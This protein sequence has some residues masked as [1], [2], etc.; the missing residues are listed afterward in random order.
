MLCPQRSYKYFV[1]L[2]D[3]RKGQP[4]PKNIMFSKAKGADPFFRPYHL[5]GPAVP[6]FA[7]SPSVSWRLVKQQA[8]QSC[9][10]VTPFPVQA[11]SRSGLIQRAR[12]YTAKTS[13]RK[14]FL[15]LLKPEFATQGWDGSYNPNSLIN[16]IFSARFE[17]ACLRS[18]KRACAQQAGA[19][20]AARS[21][22][23]RRS[24]SRTNSA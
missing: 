22:R 3:T 1:F 9:C 11:D 6:G 12:D 14:G 18:L 5:I 7:V 4:S 13:P 17:Y 15:A 24:Y 8:P 16:I 10:F 21:R 23:K 20:L 19:L 2:S